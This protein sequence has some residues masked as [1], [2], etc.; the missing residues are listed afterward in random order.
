MTNEIKEILDYL[1]DDSK[2]FIICGV[3][4]YK[5]SDYKAKVL[6]DYITN[7][8]E[9][10]EIIHK[11]KKLRSANTH[12]ENIYYAEGVLLNEPYCDIEDVDNEE[13]LKILKEEGKE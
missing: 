2:S 3:S 9:E 12:V 5:I 7:L 11:I 6:L 10:N 4:Y 1:S 8:Q 13:L